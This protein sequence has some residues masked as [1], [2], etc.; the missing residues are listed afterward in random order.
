MAPPRET[1]LTLP[2]VQVY[3]AVSA[4]INMLTMLWTIPVS[5]ASPTGECPE[6]RVFGKLAVALQP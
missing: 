5:I 4:P 3:S 2:L 1:T 6:S